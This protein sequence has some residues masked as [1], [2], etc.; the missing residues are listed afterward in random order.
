[1]RLMLLFLILV[2]PSLSYSQTCVKYDSNG[3]KH[4]YKCPENEESLRIQYDIATTRKNGK[5]I[6]KEIVTDSVCKNYENGSIKRRNCLSQAKDKF[7]D[8]CYTWTQ[9]YKNIYGNTDS[10]QIEQE[11]YCDAEYN[12]KFAR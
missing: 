6:K 5:I 1:M 8:Q 11:M 7:K 12:I 2:I 10:I 3:Q 9:K 4:Y